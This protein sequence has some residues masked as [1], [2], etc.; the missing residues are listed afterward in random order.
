MQKVFARGGLLMTPRTIFFTIQNTYINS[1]PCIDVWQGSKCAYDKGTRKIGKLLALIVKGRGAKTSLKIK[2]II[3]TYF[4][5]TF[6]IPKN[7]N[8]KNNK[9]LL[10]LGAIH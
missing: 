3:D 1:K 4:M 7:F 8:P 9:I 2:T 5:I 10:K 6:H